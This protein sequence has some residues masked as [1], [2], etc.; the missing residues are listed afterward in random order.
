M[1][2]NAFALILGNQTI[3]LTDLR[4]IL[5]PLCILHLGLK[6]WI[7]PSISMIKKLCG[8]KAQLKSNSEENN[9]LDEDLLIAIESRIIS[10]A[11]AVEAIAPALSFR[12]AS[13]IERIEE[14]M[15][16]NSGSQ[17][18]AMIIESMLQILQEGKIISW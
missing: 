13:S 5:I 1:N 7:H 14:E 10:L 18:D 3:G 2:S 16:Q 9:Q 4:V 15:K 11:Y 17:S 6:K 12:P 8:K